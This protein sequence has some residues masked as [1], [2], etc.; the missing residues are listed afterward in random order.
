MSVSALK[1][2]VS[3]KKKLQC[4]ARKSLVVSVDEVRT[5]SLVRSE[6]Q[7]LQFPSLQ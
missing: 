2:L 4:A 1:T 7:E 5:S 6:P 3:K